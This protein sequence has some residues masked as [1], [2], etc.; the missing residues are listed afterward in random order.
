MCV[1]IYISIYYERKKEKELNTFIT[2][3]IRRLFYQKLLFDVIHIIVILIITYLCPP[4]GNN[5][6][7]QNQKHNFDCDQ[8][9]N[10]LFS[11]QNLHKSN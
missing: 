6:S 7:G 2:D 10:H 1:N 4:H 9:H 3:H 5:I 11:S 8:K